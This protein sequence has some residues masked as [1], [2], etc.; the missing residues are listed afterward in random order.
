MESIENDI[1][2]PKPHEDNFL[3]KLEWFSLITANQTRGE[4]IVGLLKLFTIAKYYIKFDQY[5]GDSFTSAFV[6]AIKRLIVGE[7]MK[8]VA[9]YAKYPIETIT[10]IKNSKIVIDELLE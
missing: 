9:A 5:V 6:V 3:E 2:P 7:P 8:G 1:K 10:L 4:T